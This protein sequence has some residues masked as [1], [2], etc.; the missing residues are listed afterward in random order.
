MAPVATLETYDVLVIG[1]GIAGVTAALEAA[2][3]GARVCL[4]CQGPLFSGSSFYPG[5]WGLGLVG[6]RDA[7]DEEDLAGTIGAVG[8]G[9]ADPAL[10]AALVAGIRPAIAWL[11]EL[12]VALKQ[13]SS[14]QSAAEAAFIPCFDHTTRL[15][16]GIT[17]ESMTDVCRR[18]IARC[19]IDVHDGWE[20]ID[21]LTEDAAGASTATDALPRL[22]VEPACAV[23]SN[24]TGP[25]PVGPGAGARR[26]AS[27]VRG[28]IFHDRAARRLVALPARATVI[29]TGGTS[30][31]F[32]RRLTAADVTGS[33]GGIALLHGC[34]LTNIEFM[35]MMPGLIAPKRGLVFNEKSFRFARTDPALP[36][37]TLAE[38]SAYGPFTARLAS[39]A[40]DLA[41][42][43]EGAQGMRVRYRFPREGVPEFVRT[44]CAW[45]ADEQGIQP[46]DE[47]RIAL[48]AHASN[49]GI[50]IDAAGRTDTPGLFAAGE[51]TGGM[52]GADRI[53]GLSSA[54][55]L[56]FGRRAGRTAAAEAQA[57][58]GG[59]RD[60]AD[61]ASETVHRLSRVYLSAPES[62]AM[63]TELR[64]AMQTHAMLPRTAEGLSEGLATM[65]R[66]AERAS[67]RVQSGAPADAADN[68]LA[69]AAADDICRG[70]RLRAQL[71]L[72]R[73]MLTA[74]YER[75]E[76]R[77]AHYRA[78]APAP[79]PRYARACIVRLQTP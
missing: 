75:P 41:I 7:D 38:R 44:F 26:S 30:G 27:R 2:R 57:P 6:P 69:D 63:T 16:S 72:A 46:T 23:R 50:R 45:L 79:D 33:A 17:R 67:A 64:E 73:A 53:G 62:A 52:H 19:G 25:Q 1:S 14:A 13:P 21:L 48:Y 3:A 32:A 49:G 61:M 66:L 54:N 4:A 20:L 22:R 40:V 55:G 11:E 8:Q 28:G 71:L 74:M 35:Q 65:A 42:A 60:S 15:W 34:A 31:L 76:S 24:G 5:T 29:A 51:A 58:G 68:R 36:A 10:V 18:E 70:A 12:G 77:G 43:R 37:E 9:V 59:G 47:L 39:R 78:D 56:V